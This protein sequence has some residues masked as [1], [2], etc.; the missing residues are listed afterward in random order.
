MGKLNVNKN[1][2]KTVKSRGA[3]W[4]EALKDAEAE[5]RKAN[6]ELADWKATAAI[7]RRMMAKGQPW[8]GDKSAAS[9]PALQDS[10]GA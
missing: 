7:C 10:R 6:Q 1:V 2:N 5:I 4:A 3:S 8:P 9:Q